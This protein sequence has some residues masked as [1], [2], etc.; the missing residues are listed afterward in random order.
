MINWENE[1]KEYKT[2]YEDD[3]GIHEYVDSLVPIYY[4]D[5]LNA[6]NDMTETITDNEVGLPIWK[7]MAYYIYQDYMEKFMEAWTPFEEEEE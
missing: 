6:F 5:I 1:V 2:Q 3:E 7:V 4:G